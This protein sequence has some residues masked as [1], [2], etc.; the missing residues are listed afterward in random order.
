M[1]NLPKVSLKHI[2]LT[3]FGSVLILVGACD[4][5]LAGG[6]T[7]QNLPQGPQSEIEAGQ[8][9]G[10]DFASVSSDCQKIK[11]FGSVGE[12]AQNRP[13]ISMNLCEDGV[14]QVRLFGV[15]EGDGLTVV[16]NET[17]KEG[18]GI[19]TVL[20][21]PAFS[22]GFPAQFERVPAASSATTILT[23]QNLNVVEKTGT[24]LICINASVCSTSSA[25]SRYSI[26]EIEEVEA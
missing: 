14:S 21:T 12:Q 9:S 10:S 13:S 3:F 18:F 16:R 6:T 19:Q 2:R 11:F 17:P 4:G 26:L 5:F 7:G 20:D 15:S 25:D 23:L 1:V 22:S 8:S 24:A